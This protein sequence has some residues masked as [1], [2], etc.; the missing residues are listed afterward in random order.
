MATQDSGATPPAAPPTDSTE[1]EAGSS[2]ASYDE[3]RRLIPQLAAELDFLRASLREHNLWLLRYGHSN[4]APPPDA[5]LGPPGSAPP[6]P[7]AEQT[8]PSAANSELPA[9]SI[10]DVPPYETGV[11]EEVAQ[12][13]DQ[14]MEW[15]KEG[16]DVLRDYSARFTQLARELQIPDEDV[17]GTWR[18]AA[19]DN[20]LPDYERVEEREELMVGGVGEVPPPY[21]GGAFAR[22]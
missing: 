15:L 22:R 2:R 9:Y 17:L 13:K 14:L 21:V 4:T 3:L 11:R 1:P 12:R 5:P 8:D 19:P 10:S 16:E 20:A 18:E 6:E 7:E